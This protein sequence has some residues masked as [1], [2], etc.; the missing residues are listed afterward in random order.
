MKLARMSMPAETLA[1]IAMVNLRMLPEAVV[2]ADTR[3]RDAPLIWVSEQFT[4]ITGYS[5]AEALGRNCRY[6]NGSDRMQPELEKLRDAIRS[7]TSTTVTIR[8][9]RK[10]GTLFWNE[11]TITP[12]LG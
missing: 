2:V 5:P 9:Y 7:A 11:L 8:N 12:H 4:A 1:E 6:L 3:E 10:D